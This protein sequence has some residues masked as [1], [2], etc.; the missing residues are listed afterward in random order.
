MPYLTQL[1][2]FRISQPIAW[3][4]VKNSTQKYTI[5]LSNNLVNPNKQIKKQMEPDTRSKTYMH[6]YSTDPEL[7]DS[8]KNLETSNCSKLALTVVS[9]SLQIS[10]TNRTWR[11]HEIITIWL[12][13]LGEFC[14]LSKQANVFPASTVK[15]ISHRVVW[16]QIKTS[17]ETVCV[18]CLTILTVWGPVATYFGDMEHGDNMV[19]CG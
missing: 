11:V 19:I 12:Q 7:R 13:H 1:W 18:G 15:H 6:A 9:K 2:W 16:C 14:I 17:S 5:Q 4:T 10:S 3:L 8:A